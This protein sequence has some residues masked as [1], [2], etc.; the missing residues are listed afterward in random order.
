[1]LVGG[2]LE[3][4]CPTCR[5]HLD[6][7]SD[8]VV[9]PNGHSFPTLGTTFDFLPGAGDDDSYHATDSDLAREESGAAWRTEQYL[10]PVLKRIL[11]ERQ[12]EPI[13]DDGCGVGAVV[14]ELVGHGFEAYGV[15]PGVR[16][17]KWEASP[18][19]ER[20]FRADGTSL[21]FP[22]DT[23]GTIVSSGVLEHLGEP[24]PFGKR[25]PAQ[26]GY[27]R[28]ALRVLKPGGV[29]LMGAPNGAHPIDYWHGRWPMRLHIP[30]ES[31][32]PN[33]PRVREWVARSGYPA[34]VT[35]LSPENYLSFQRIRQQWVG[36]VFTSS[37]QATF[38]TITRFPALADSPMN[39]WLIACIRKR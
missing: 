3:L 14:S 12:G 27:I 19:P 17:A 26:V 35:F 28:E 34:D 7:V 15:D 24:L 16:T 20:L 39:P 4:T 25:K 13:L 10:L 29:A 23:F 9:C 37:M 33:G 2:R 18:I 36:R 1:M 22:D 30:Y 5:S 11:G 38:R 21:P 6:S 8:G 31:W 32:M